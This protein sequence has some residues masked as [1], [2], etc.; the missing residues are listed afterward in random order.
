M[1]LIDELIM[2]DAG[3][4]PGSSDTAFLKASTRRLLSIGRQHLSYESL[5]DFEDV[6]SG[7]WRPN[8]RTNCIDAVMQK[9]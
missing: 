2:M 8:W 6:G 1:Q 5:S 7:A 4:V 3:S 9:L